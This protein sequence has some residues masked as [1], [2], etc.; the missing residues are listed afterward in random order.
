L[1]TNG[2]KK[3]AHRFSLSLLQENFTA[4]TTT[5]NTV[6]YKISLTNDTAPTVDLLRWQ[7]TPCH[8]ST[9]ATHIII[10]IDRCYHPKTTT[11]IIIFIN[12]CYT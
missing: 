11:H 1:K 6:C 3:N 12:H 8:H 5:D 10:F 4:A 2:G 7:T 9:T